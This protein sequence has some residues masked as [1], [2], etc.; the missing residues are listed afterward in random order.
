MSSDSIDIRHVAKLARIALS[1]EEVEKFSAELGD[2]LTHVNAISQLD[3]EHIEATA[4][5]VTSRNVERPDE[6]AECLPRDLVLAMAPQA[7][8][9]YFRVPRIIAEE[10]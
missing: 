10:E 6:F 3:T 2:L 1:A 9:F 5:V 8:G 7:Q 4:Q